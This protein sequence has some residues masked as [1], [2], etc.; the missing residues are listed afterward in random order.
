MKKVLGLSV[1]LGLLLATA[2]TGLA[3]QIGRAHV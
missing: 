1:G 3:F 2:G